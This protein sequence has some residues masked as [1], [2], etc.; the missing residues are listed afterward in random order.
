V[1]YYLSLF[2]QKKK[3]VENVVKVSCFRSLELKEPIKSWHLYLLSKFHTLFSKSHSLKFTIKRTCQRSYLSKVAY[4]YEL[5]QKK[6]KL[7][8]IIAKVD[9]A[10]K[11]KC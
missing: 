8:Y 9:F 3:I 2:L 1:E 11:K 5:S 4:N 7:F 10:K 6:L